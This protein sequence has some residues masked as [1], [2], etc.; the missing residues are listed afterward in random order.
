MEQMAPG[1]VSASAGLRVLRAVRERL[2]AVAERAEPAVV[3]LAIGLTP[4]QLLHLERKYE[5]NNADYRKEWLQAPPAERDDKR[6]EQFLERSEMIYGKLDEPQR[7]A[8]RRQFGKSTFDPARILAERQR[9]QRDALQ[10]LRRIAGQPVSF[11]EARKL[12]RGFL[13]RVREPPEPAANAYQHALIEESCRSFAALHNS[14]SA[15]QR[16]T[17]VRRLRAYQRDLRELSAQQ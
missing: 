16:E 11:D 9:R 5:K 14:T 10:T 17:A 6:F 8:L 7:S 12:L 4:E 1:D 3:T 15:A 13:D 2:D